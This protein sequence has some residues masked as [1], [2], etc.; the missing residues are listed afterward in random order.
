MAAGQIRTL[1]SELESTFVATDESGGQV[2]VY[3]M[4]LRQSVEMYDGTH[5][6]ISNPGI[7]FQLRDG[8]RVHSTQPEGT[9]LVGNSTRTLTAP[10]G[11][12]PT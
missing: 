12:F 9:F 5:E 2:T 11:T 4:R 10:A 1:G 3:V 7:Y 6:P 8:T